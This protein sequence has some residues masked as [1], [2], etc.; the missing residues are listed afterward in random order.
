MYYNYQNIK[1]ALKKVGVTKG[2]TV[3]VKIVL[4]FLGPFKKLDIES[5]LK[6]H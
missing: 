5:I 6:A 2:R 3:L 4:R 1:G